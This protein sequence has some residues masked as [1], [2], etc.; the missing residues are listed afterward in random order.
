MPQPA[1]AATATQPADIPSGRR[2][3]ARTVGLAVVAALGAVLQA[4]LAQA[5]APIQDEAEPVRSTATR[6]AAAAPQVLASPVAAAARLGVQSTRALPTGALSTR[7][8]PAHAVVAAAGPTYT[9][10]S[11][12]TVGHISIRTGIKIKDIVAANGLDSRGFI[13]AGQVL[14]LPGGAAAPPAPASTPASTGH[15][16]VAGDTVGHIAIR[17]GVSV[18]SVLQ[19]NGLKATSIIRPGQVLDV[20]GAKSTGSTR[21]ATPAQAPKSTTSYTV[22]GGDTLSHIA[23]RSGTTVAALRS[24]NPSLDSRGTIHVGQTIAVPA[25]S[26]PMPNTFAGRTY[27]NTTVAAATVNRDTLAA[28]SVPSR[29]QM[30]SII[31]DT[32]RQL[33]VDPAVA[34]AIAFQE[35]G[36][37][38]RAVSPA[39]AVGAMQVIPSSGRWAADLTGRPVDLLDPHDNA[40]AGVAIIRA[41]MRTSPTMDD[42]IAGYYQGQTSVRRNG[43]FADTRRYVANVQTLTARYR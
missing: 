24:A 6:S 33:G 28:R 10:K 26:A 21:S 8:V 37:N 30:R 7:A 18:A 9:V 35:S 11:G 17:A 41:L 23:V 39:N 5:A 16:V 3:G 42:A 43:M 1:G 12:D 38:Q 25:Q 4:P 29:D 31:S 19:A 27:P 36:F 32:A 22:K 34:L 20:P 13:R 2:P 14:V 15:T 40:R